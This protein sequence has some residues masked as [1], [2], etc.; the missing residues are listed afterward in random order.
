MLVEEA[1][2]IPGGRLLQAERHLDAPRLNNNYA[3]T[4]AHCGKN[5]SEWASSCAVCRQSVVEVKAPAIGAP[6]AETYEGDG[7]LIV[8]HPDAEVVRDAV[9]DVVRTVRVELA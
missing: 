2:E 8:R 4:K 9:Q 3:L 1:L 5:V 6:R 7:Y